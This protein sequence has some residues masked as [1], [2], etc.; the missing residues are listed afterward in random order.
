MQKQEIEAI[1]RDY[2][3]ANPEVLDEAFKALQEKREKEAAAE[4]GGGDR[5]EQRSDLQF[6]APDGARQPGRRDHAGRV[7]RLQLRLLQA[8]ASPT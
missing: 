2:L 5:Q 7:L 3:L 1:I 8:R 6:A 4:A